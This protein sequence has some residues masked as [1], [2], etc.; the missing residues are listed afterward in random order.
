MKI[1][2]ASFECAPIDVA[3]IPKIYNGAIVGVQITI[4]CEGL[5][6]KNG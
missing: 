2:Y 4:F 1:L 5:S 6:K 3:N